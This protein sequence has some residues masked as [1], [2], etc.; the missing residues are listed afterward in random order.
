MNLKFE[1]QPSAKPTADS[2]RDARL[3]DPGFGRV[4]TDHMVTSAT[5]RGRAGTARAS[6]RAPAS[7]SIR[8]P[9][10]CTTRRKSS[11]GSRP[12]SATT[13]ASPCSAPTPT[14]GASATS[15]DAHG[16]AAAARGAVH[17]GHRATRPHRPRLDPGRRGQP[18]SAAL[19]VRHR[20]LP[21]RETVG[22]IHLR[23]SSPA[24]SAPISR[25]A[26]RRSRSGCQRTIPARRPAA[27]ARRNAA[28]ITPPACVAQAEAIEHGCDQVVFLDAA[29]H[30]WV[31]ELG[32]MNVFFVFDDG[33]LATPPL[34]GTILPGITRDSII[35]LAR[36]R[37]A[38]CARSATAI[39]QWRADAASGRLTR[40]LRLRHRR[41]GHADRQG[42]LGERR[43]RHQRRRRRSGRD[44]AAQETRRYPVR[45]C[46]RPARMGPKGALSAGST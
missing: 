16:D 38:R 45:T 15:A 18:L 19:H 44:V 9:P 26:R 5:T 4:F 13:A 22:R 1:I 41:G 7:R 20:G 32:G 25:A 36:G 33:S 42:A 34:T 28:A 40:G 12:T 2:E 37:P 3:V 24:R 29:E 10:C 23:A 27:P 8:P 31:E 43:F 30:R 46:V 21:R 11:R 6:T 17:R 39:D 35:A 14:P